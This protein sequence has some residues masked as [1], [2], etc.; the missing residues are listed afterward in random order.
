MAALPFTM[1]LNG[2]RTPGE[3][4]LVGRAH[5]GKTEF[6]GTLTKR[7]ELDKLV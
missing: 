3:E 4:W 7:R 1:N 6:L 5:L 2:R